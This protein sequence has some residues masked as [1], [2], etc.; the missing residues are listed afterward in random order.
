MHAGRCIVRNL[1]FDI[2]EEHLKKI[3][4]PFGVIKEINI[5][6]AAPKPTKNG[7]GV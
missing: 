4:T 6:Q 2:K 3:F 1:N 7:K 5:P